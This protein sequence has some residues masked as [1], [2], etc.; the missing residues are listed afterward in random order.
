MAGPGPTLMSFSVSCFMLIVYL[1][2]LSVLPRGEYAAGPGP[3]V[4][5]ASERSRVRGE[6]PEL[7]WGCIDEQPLRISSAPW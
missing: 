4:F 6:R 7:A 1:G 5:T 3:H 2:P